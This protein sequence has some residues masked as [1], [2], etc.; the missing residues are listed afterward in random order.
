M[1]RPAAR[2]SRSP[3]PYAAPA[4][5]GAALTPPPGSVPV[6]AIILARDERRDIAR[7][8]RSAGWCAQV[9]VVDSGSTDGTPQIARELGA[10]VWE[11]PWRGFA[12][13]REWAMRQPGVQHDWVY[14]LDADEWVPVA[15]AAEIAERLGR[16]D[17]AAYTHRRRFFFLGR[18]IAHCGWYAN[19]WQARLL[20]RRSASF[21]TA[22]E[23]SERPSVNGTILPLEHD[24]IDQDSK[25]L[26]CWLHK[27]ITYAELEARRRGT[28][29]GPLR[30]LRRVLGPDRATSSRP[31]SR[32]IARDVVL[33]LLP[34][35]MV[36]TFVYMYVFRSGWRDGWQ[37]LAFCLHRAW[38]EKM[39]RLLGTPA[40]APQEAV[41]PLDTAPITPITPT[42]TATVLSSAQ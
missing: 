33:P 4:T 23:F 12:G 31:L 3:V 41:Y 39:I 5:A 17:C 2:P 8:V 9:V 24:V 18:W 30:Q 32:A 26:A 40:A 34:C 11:Q 21:A 37:G 13:Q 25:G 15:L 10:T 16:E 29:S 36:V 42:A 35:K 38:H 20:D 22:E 1:I 19:S 7:A 28:S 27:H 14:F 6:T